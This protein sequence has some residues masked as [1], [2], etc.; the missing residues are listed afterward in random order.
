L[1]E[2]RF[3]REQ[4]DHTDLEQVSRRAKPVSKNTLANM[5][6][7]IL[8]RSKIKGI[9]HQFTKRE[10]T[11]TPIFHG[12]RYWWMKHPVGAKMQPAIRAML[13][14][15]KIGLASSYYRPSEDELLEE[16]VKAIGKGYFTIS[17][18][19]KLRQKVEMLEIEKSQYEILQSD[20]T[21]FKES[22]E[23]KLEHVIDILAAISAENERENM[24]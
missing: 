16:Y 10:R 11:L 22:I 2:H 21:Q 6:Q 12:C 15:H 1:P 18:E 19:N 14:S 3:I 5:M 4:F 8:A 9:N 23:N 20:L 7:A 24:M 13:L 17:E